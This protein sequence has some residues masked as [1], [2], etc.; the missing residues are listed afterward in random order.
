MIAQ[1]DAAT[2]FEQHRRLLFAIAYR[3]LGSADEAEDAVQ[4]AYLRY[5]SAQH[6]ENPRAFLTTTV[7]RLCLDRLKSARVRREQYIG[8]WLPEPVLTESEDPC[9]IPGKSLELAESVS[10]A[11]LLLLESLSPLERAVFLLHEVFDYGYGEVA[12]MVGQSEAACRQHVHRAKTR[13][14]A[15]RHR[16]H[17]E[18]DDATRVAESFLRAMQSG[19]VQDVLTL[20]APDVVVIT[21]GGGKAAAALNPIVGRDRALRFMQGLGRKFSTN[22]L[23]VEAAHINHMPALLFFV[24]GQLDTA[25]TMILEG[26]VVTAMHG[27]RNPDKLHAIAAA[28]Q[29]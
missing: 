25:M 16:F 18:P 27:V 22:E 1:S 28:L 20:I 12:A 13:L 21:D 17:A 26:G 29:H 8:E 7:S 15:E 11:F 3:M 23:R 4:D 2:V 6:V 5:R 10:T 24:D 19:D 9:C 14:R